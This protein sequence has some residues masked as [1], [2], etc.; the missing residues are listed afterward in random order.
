MPPSSLWSATNQTVR[1]RL[2]DVNVRQRRSANGRTGAVEIEFDV[3]ACTGHGRCYSLSPDLF[4]PD[5]CGHALDASGPVPE[6]RE[7]DAIRAAQNCPE[8][9]IRILDR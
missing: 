5:D 9:A 2:A 6:A 1:R 7:Q 3:D 8:Q 4:E